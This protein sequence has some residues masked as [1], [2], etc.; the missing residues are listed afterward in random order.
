MSCKVLSRNQAEKM[1][2]EIDA[3]KK[4]DGKIT[5]EELKIYMMKEFHMTKEET[6]K[7]FDEIDKDKN[8][9][10]TLAEFTED[11]C[12]KPRLQC[13]EYE[14]KHADTDH[15]GK[16][17]ISEF[18]KYLSKGTSG[19]KDVE[20]IKKM[21]KEADKDNSGELTKEEFIAMCQKY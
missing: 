17:N 4:R 8:K 18:T 5:P 6:D 16:L 13:F 12:K 11:V 21:F 3:V 2:R 1:F 10:I 9:V 20:K 7:L 15:S 14:F 19:I